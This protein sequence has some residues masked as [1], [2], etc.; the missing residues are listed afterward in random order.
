MIG[1]WKFECS[2]IILNEYYGFMFG[3]Y[4]EGSLYIWR[5]ISIGYVVI[6]VFIE[7]YWLKLIPSEIL[8]FSLLCLH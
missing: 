6:K 8:S 7:T 5:S 1:I 4:E 2:I 3:V